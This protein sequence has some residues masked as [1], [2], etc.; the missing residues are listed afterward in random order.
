V[1]ELN[2]PYHLKAFDGWVVT[3]PDERIVMRTTTA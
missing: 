1:V 2:A 3:A